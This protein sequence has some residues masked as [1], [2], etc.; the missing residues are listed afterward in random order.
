MVGKGAGN[1][2]GLQLVQ[3]F[4]VAEQGR[5]SQHS[6]R[7]QP[8]KRFPAILASLR[9][10]ERTE[11]GKQTPCEL[12]ARVYQLSHVVHGSLHT[13]E[14]PNYLKMGSDKALL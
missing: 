14:P 2:I 3:A 1:E 5:S 12:L 6:S 8:S 13:Q 11:T 10:A 4:G 9:F 7:T